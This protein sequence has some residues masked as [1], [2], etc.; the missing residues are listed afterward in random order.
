MAKTP[1]KAAS[2]T[3]AKPAAPK[4]S[5]AQKPLATGD[6]DQFPK[7]T[8]RADMGEGLPDQA[9]TLNPNRAK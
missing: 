7:H 5:S 2:K 4:S 8:F 1:R 3:P 6:V 9:S